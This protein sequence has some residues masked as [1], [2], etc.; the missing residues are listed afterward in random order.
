MILGEPDKTKHPRKISA[1]AACSSKSAKASNCR[2]TSS[3]DESD[4]V[5]TKRAK[6][7]K[8]EKRHLDT[9]SSEDN[10]AYEKP[11]KGNVAASKKRES[12]RKKEVRV[13]DKKAGSESES[14]RSK[15]AQDTKVAS[16]RS[17]DTESCED[18]Y[19]ER[20]AKL[21]VPKPDK[22]GGSKRKRKALESRPD[23]EMESSDDDDTKHQ[24]HKISKADLVSEGGSSTKGG[25]HDVKD[26]RR[27][28]PRT[29]PSASSTRSRRQTWSVRGAAARRVAS[30][31]RRPM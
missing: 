2:T 19:S 26:R 16:R 11:K 29:T 8:K 20:E 17:K 7:S 22:M 31:R 21:R 10:Y 3:E 14:L 23:L 25:K 4:K 30:T 6:R 27:R 12:R 5:A 24:L 15:A 18:D 28:A 9:Q 13:K 1:S